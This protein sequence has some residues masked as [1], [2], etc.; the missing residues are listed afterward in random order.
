TCNGSAADDCYAKWGEQLTSTTSV[1]NGFFNIFF[2]GGKPWA[3]HRGYNSIERRLGLL[4]RKMA[5]N[6]SPVGDA[7]FAGKWNSFIAA[8]SDPVRPDWS[9][10]VIAG[11]SDGSQLAMYILQ[12]RPVVKG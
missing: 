2:G 9:K 10:I 12:S 3:G 5:D 11:H 4:L 1:D 7:Q 8:G 6:P